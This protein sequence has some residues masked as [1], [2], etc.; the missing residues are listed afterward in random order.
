MVDLSTLPSLYDTMRRE[1][2]V[3]WELVRRPTS[4]RRG[5]KEKL[6]FLAGV[7]YLVNCES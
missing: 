2:C 1:V 4:G 6:R 5:M 7:V 3:G